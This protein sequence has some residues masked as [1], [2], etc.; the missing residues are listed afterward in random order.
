MKVIQHTDGTYMVRTQEDCYVDFKRFEV[1]HDTI[2]T[3]K[4]YSDEKGISIATFM[5][6]VASEFC[7]AW[8]EFQCQN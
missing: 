7:K 5:F 2:L 1:I 3:V 8:R 6:E 4:L